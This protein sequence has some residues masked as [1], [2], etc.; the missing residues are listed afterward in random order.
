MRLYT[1]PLSMFGTK[2]WIAALEKG[3][4]CEVVM[5]QFNERSGYEPKHPDV[6][7]LNPKAQVPV[8]VDGDLVLFDSTQIFEYFE[9]LRPQPP[10]W[11]TGIR[12]RAR[13]R[14]LELQSDEVFF[15][16][17]V[18]L[19]GLQDALDGSAA[20]TARD[21]IDRHRSAMERQLGEQPFLCG[22]FGYVDIA[23]YMAQLFAE[24]MGAPLTTSTPRLL[25]WRDRM[26]SRASVRTALPPLVAYLRAN[27]RPV[28]DFLRNIAVPA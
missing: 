21:A 28:P 4:D 9:D 11:P 19:M 1:G 15:P 12:A 3:L 5:V 26:T 2:A 8:L 18:N 24:R 20:K 22:D 7:R 14:N 23:F 16:Q 6:L 17:V 10:L 13:A 27:S 25:R